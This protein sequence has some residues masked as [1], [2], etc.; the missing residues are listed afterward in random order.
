M[1]NILL[2][3]IILLNANYLISQSINIESCQ[4]KAKINFPLIKQYGLIEQT[5]RFN[6][7]NANKG[8]L[9]QLS[10]SARGTYQS[11]VTELPFKIA[12][13]DLPSLSKD[14]YQAVLEANQLLWDG[15][16]IAAQKKATISGYEA[17]KQK[18]EVDLFSLKERV[19]QLFFGILMFNEQIKQN[20]ILKDELK[21]NYDRV[22]AY[23]KNGVAN[24]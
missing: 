18:L 11:Q 7:D 6:I 3:S 12:G 1:K 20:G 22:A 4:E 2:I 8:Y 24:Q 15:G 16:S 19:N 14:Q 21:T 5:A 9:P 10:F 17:E 13:K 23:K